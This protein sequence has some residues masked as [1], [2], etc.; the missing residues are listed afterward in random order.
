MAAINRSDLKILI[1]SADGSNTV[2][3]SKLVQTLSYF[4]DIF[5]PMITISMIVMSTGISSKKSIYQNL[6]IVGGERVKLTIPSNSESN[7]DLEFDDLF[8]QSVSDYISETEREVFNLNL[9]TREAITN[10]TTRIG[11]RFPKG[12]PISVHVESIIR[13]G[14]ETDKKLNVDETMN[15]Y[16]FLG[17]MKKPFTILTWLA[18]KS[19]PSGG[20]KSTGGTAGYFFYETQE[21]FN[22]RSIDGLASSE[23]FSE[24][25]YYRPST[26]ETTD[27]DKDFNILEYKTS[28]NNNLISNL[29]RGSYCTHRMFFDPLKFTFTAQQEGLFKNSDYSKTT[30]FTG[31]SLELPMPPVD[32]KGKS[33]GDLPSR[34]ITGVLDIGTTELNKSETSTEENADPMLRQSQAMMRY[35]N[36]FSSKV[37]MIIPLNTNLTAGALITC[38][39]PEI[40]RE[41]TKKADNELSGLYMIKELVHFFNIDASY[42]KLKLVKD[43]YGKKN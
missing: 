33:L 22:F 2:D 12:T 14:L 30:E 11:K 17:N 34:L 35:N 38:V 25:Y 26:I 15:P 42:T 37:E 20:E 10:E 40:N 24:K 31:K 36:L 29:E 27:D 8:V 19:V 4:E 7:K 13:E 32:G 16:G 23:P 21:G 9:V 41:E 28:R 6:P 18:S 5:S 1:T 3:I 39:Y 43:T